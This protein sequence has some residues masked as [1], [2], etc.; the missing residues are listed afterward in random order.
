[1]D[2]VRAFL[3]VL[4]AE[5]FW[6]LTVVCT[7]VG[8]L[9]WNMA[10]SDLD[11][12]FKKRKSAIDRIYS[13]VNDIKNELIHPNDDVNTGDRK[14]AQQQRD[15][16]KEVWVELYESQRTAV[17]YWP[18]SISDEFVAYMQGKKFGDKISAEM[19]GFYNNYITSRFDAL[20]EIV[21]AQEQ[22]AGRGGRG[23]YSGGDYTGGLAVGGGRDADLVE[24]EEDYLVEW[25][26][27][28]ELKGKL[29]F[30][31][32][33]SSLEVWVTQED[34]WVYETLLKVIKR[35]NEAKGATRPDNTAV[36]TIV[37]LQVGQEAGTSKIGGSLVIP[38]ESGAVSGG[39]GGGEGGR[40]GYGEGGYGRGGEGGYGEEGYGRGGFDE[41]GGYG[42]GGAGG[43]AGGAIDEGI[44]LSNRYLQDDGTPEATGSVST[45]NSK[46]FR[47][48]PVRMRLNMDEK[49]IP[50]ILLECANATLP[51]E[52]TRVR[53]NP[54]QS[55]AGAAGG[56]RGG[57]ARRNLDPELTDVVI[58]GVVYI[59]NEADVQKLTIPGEELPPA[60]D[61]SISLAR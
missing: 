15:L 9:C 20:L 21:E 17:L 59:Y 19:R 1:M 47:K 5:R 39:R 23:G 37:E 45:V 36:R 44:L 51:I 29:E 18:K 30:Q 54:D 2:Q 34:L 26:D 35:T 8:V 57:A 6:V 16:V 42:R 38:Q 7:L 24:E 31:G 61:D 43:S 25:L 41:E 50:R 60:P 13:T 40:G 48:L 53:I 33:P 14:Q 28:L 49:Y 10:S 46:E 27:Q 4:W 12:E 55:S 58:H 52:V 56:R 32:E 11:A 22:L 3:S